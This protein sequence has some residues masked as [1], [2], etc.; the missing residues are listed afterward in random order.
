[1]QP[2]AREALIAAAAEQVLWDKIPI[3]SLFVSMKRRDWNLVPR[4][5]GHPPGSAEFGQVSGQ[6]VLGDV[7]VAGGVG[8]EGAAQ[9]A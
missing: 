2:A 8:M 7:L 6:E 4:C 3:L 9:V 1:L 5:S